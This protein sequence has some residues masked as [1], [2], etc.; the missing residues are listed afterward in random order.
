MPPTAPL[1]RQAHGGSER[2]QEGQRTLAYSPGLQP[3]PGG[4]LGFCSQSPC[5]SRPASCRWES[6]RNRCPV[7]PLQRAQFKE[8]LAGDDTE[9]LRP[10]ASTRGK[11]GLPAPNLTAETH[12]D[13]VS[14]ATSEVTVPGVP[15]GSFG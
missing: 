6:S 12:K 5:P 4:P 10:R 11:G 14:Q 7:L 3:L 2:R 8:T 15:G 1:D 13:S 9:G